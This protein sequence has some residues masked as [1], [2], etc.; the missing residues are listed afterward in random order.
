[1]LTDLHP[2]R[3]WRGYLAT[4]AVALAMA[5]VQFLEQRL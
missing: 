5:A 2:L 4:A 1:M 3:N